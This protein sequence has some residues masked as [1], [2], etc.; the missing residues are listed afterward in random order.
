MWRVFMCTAGTSGERRCATSEMPLAQKR[1]SVSAPGICL[2]NSG[3]N[4]PYTVETLTPTF[5][6]TRP[7]IIAIVPPPP[8][9]RAH[10]LRSNRPGG[11][12][13]AGAG[14]GV[15]DRLEFGADA[16]AQL[17]EPARGAFLAA[18]AAS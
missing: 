7:R 2:R 12:L 9:S 18:S 14:I 13:G 5:S 4:S 16:V 3:A 1:G 10:G 6:K 11:P 15:L 8:P 17:L